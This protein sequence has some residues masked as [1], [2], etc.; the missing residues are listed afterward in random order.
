AV[1]ALAAGA[2]PLVLAFNAVSTVT[3]VFLFIG[4]WTPIAGV[5]VALVAAWHAFVDP[6]SAS[7][8]GMLGVLGVG[9]ALLGPGAWSLDARLFGWKRVDIRNGKSSGSGKAP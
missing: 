9:L 6:G 8:Y 4:F 3:G 5:L 7:F 1:E 2:P